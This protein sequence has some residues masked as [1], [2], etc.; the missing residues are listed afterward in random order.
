MVDHVDRTKRSLIMGAVHSKDTT[1]ELAVRKIVRRLGYRHRLH[2]VALPGRPD[3][4]F[5]TQKKVV[6][7][8]GCFWHRHRKCR[9]ASSPKTRRKFW[10]AKFAANVTRDRR[11]KR[12]LKRMGWDVFTVWQCEL[13]KVERLTGRLD[14][15]LSS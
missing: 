15:F 12:E 13:K 10:E 6:F 9:Y 14:D 7:V 2:V 8:H 4:V 5:P 3:L 11:T 1:P